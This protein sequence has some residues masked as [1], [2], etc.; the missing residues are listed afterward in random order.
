[1]IKAIT[2]KALALFV[3]ASVALS[4]TI[5]AV[6]AENAEAGYPKILYTFY[7]GSGS[8]YRVYTYNEGAS[9]YITD[10]E[11]SFNAESMGGD[12]KMI[13]AKINVGLVYNRGVANSTGKCYALLGGYISDSAGKIKQNNLSSVMDSGY[14]MAD[15]R[16]DPGSDN[17]YEQVNL[18]DYYIALGG[19][20]WGDTNVLDFEHK[21]I[22]LSEFYSQGDI[23]SFKR[24]QIPLNDFR[25]KSGGGKATKAFRGY[26]GKDKINKDEDSA[27]KPKV[28][29]AK[30]E[31]VSCLS[32]IYICRQK[33]GA[34]EETDLPDRYNK[35]YLGNMYVTDGEMQ[36][37]CTTSFKQN[38]ESIDVVYP[39]DITVTTDTYGVAGTWSAVRYDKDGKAAET[40]PSVSVD[41]NLSKKLSFTFKDCEYSDRIMVTLG[42]STAELK[43]NQYSLGMPQGFAVQPRKGRLEATLTWFA[44]SYGTAAKYYIYR[45]GAKIAEISGDTLTYTDNKDM[46][47]NTYYKW[48]VSAVDANGAESQRCEEIFAAVSIVTAPTDVTV[49][50]SGDNEITVS[51]MASD[52]AESYIVMCDGNEIGKT[53]TSSFKHIDAEYGRFYNYSVVSVNS[54]GI[55]SLPSEVFE[56]LAEDPEYSDYSSLGN[57]GSISF[58]RGAEENNAYKLTLGSVLNVNALREKRWASLRFILT[59]PQGTDFDGVK[60]SLM[61]KR[62]M[63]GTD[64]DMRTSVDLKDF[65]KSDAD[66]ASVGRAAAERKTYVEI[67]L[68]KFPDYGEFFAYSK[69]QYDKFDYTKISEV[70]FSADTKAISKDIT[71]SASDMKIVTHDE[72]EEPTKPD[73]KKPTP[74]PGGRPVH[75]GGGGGGSVMR[76]VTDKTQNDNNGE[77]D[78]NNQNENN[79]NEPQRDNA[80]SD[81]NDEPWAAESISSLTAAGIVSGYPDKT[82]RP[83]NTVTREEF[84]T[85]IVKALGISDD[86]AECTMTDVDGGEWYYKTIAAAQNNGIVNGYEDGTFGIGRTISREEACT[87]LLRSAEV[88]A[89][90]LVEKYNTMVF[91]DNDQISEYAAEA[92]KKLQRAGIVNGT[93]NDR[94]APSDSLT[95]A[96]AAKLIYEFSVIGGKITKTEDK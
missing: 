38:G 90:E 85:M 68:E 67:P 77:T 16:L 56:L 66:L 2:R 55:K 94:F 11:D 9:N 27:D 46:T 26:N 87:M 3:A 81:I 83:S 34:A 17:R 41:G 75:K 36:P 45:D 18:D 14:V 60:L 10:K 89:V 40:A 53:E 48:C 35:V 61:Q 51:W 20:P 19:Y 31:R 52:N 96:M 4:S 23:G 63:S 93:D 80:L 76:P 91:A 13:S 28:E 37:Y 7:D 15:L 86:G 1:M 25:L 24:V 33:L 74:D 69:E 82:F 42:T 29:D 59:A 5:V 30:F 73:D 88:G 50:L 71:F 43:A 78:N 79:G 6:A 8:G 58:V 57:I 70:E 72:K 92:V 47:D 54:D 12:E 21:L 65:V 62:R 44:P 22:P 95:R 84:V 32:L 49:E 39:G 64:Y